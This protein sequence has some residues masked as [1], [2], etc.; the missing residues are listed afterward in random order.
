MTTGAT[1]STSV[2]TFG[3]Q[4]STLYLEMLTRPL[5]PKALLSPWF[6]PFRWSRQH[7]WLEQH[8]RTDTT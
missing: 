8:S 1:P 3:K 7:H 6:L 5:T 4:Q 2:V